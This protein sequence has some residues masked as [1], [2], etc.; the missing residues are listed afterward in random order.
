[1]S[2]MSWPHDVAAPLRRA[3]ALGAALALLGA[4]PA[5]GQLVI[6][7]EDD[8]GQEPS[9]SVNDEVLD[10]LGPPAGA[11]SPDDMPGRPLM[12][13]PPTRPAE[14]ASGGEA[15]AP[16]PAGPPPEM[17]TAAAGRPP[18]TPPLPERK[19]SGPPERPDL[20]VSPAAPGDAD[21]ES[22]ALRMPDVPS[23]PDMAPLDVGPMPGAEQ[24]AEAEAE[25]PQLA[26]RPPEA[27]P[28]PELALT[29]LPPEPD[30]AAPAE[31]ATAPETPPVPE[32]PALDEP[33]VEEPADAAAPEAPQL[34]VAPPGGTDGDGGAAGATDAGDTDAADD[35]AA[36]PLTAMSMPVL[37]AAAGLPAPDERLSI[38]FDPEATD[39][40]GDAGAV[41][42]NL[43]DRLRADDS[44][45][46]QLFS[47]A[48]S[49]SASAAEARTRSLH[50]ALAVRQFMLD[51]DIRVTR[52]DIRALGNSAPEGPADRIDLV[53]VN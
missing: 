2:D 41:L 34:A 37:G 47:Y 1:M 33:E 3:A 10:R 38:A 46:L 49:T 19:P 30:D 8:S 9:V 35:A 32:P 11:P 29:P 17:E 6:G 22:Q 5:A 28:E 51:R 48:G 12:L 16:R 40:P 21:D 31:E 43:A 42:G 7:G 27:P 36:G 24:P 53:L 45:R 4:G 26:R 25:A 50:R 39:L 44:L 14:R 23:P 20:A 13:T 15:Q 52:I 18:F